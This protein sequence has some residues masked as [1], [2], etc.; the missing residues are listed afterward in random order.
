MEKK[1]KVTYLSTNEKNINTV[2]ENLI[3]NHTKTK[4][5][6]KVKKAANQ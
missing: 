4:K 1:I 5:Y 3:E 6:N 2:I